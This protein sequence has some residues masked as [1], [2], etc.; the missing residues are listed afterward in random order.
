MN[1]FST[2]ILSLLLTLP[3]AAG[4]SAAM[5]F[6]R[7]EMELVVV[8]GSCAEKEK[9]G[10]RLAL[11]LT[12][13]QGS[14]ANGQPFTGYFNGPDMQTGR[15]SGHDLGQLQVEYPDKPDRPQGDTLW[16]SATPDGL[17]GELREKPQPDSTNCYFEKAVLRLR[18][19]AGDGKAQSEYARQK[20]LF[21]A[22]VYF[23]SGQ[24]LLQSDKPEEALLDLTKSLKLRTMA[25]PNDPDRAIP[26]VSIAIA[27]IMAGREA[28][29]RA[30]MH[31]LYGDK[32]E[33]GDAILKERLALAESLCSAEQYLENDA[34]R[35]AFL[36]LLDMVAREFG[37]LKGAAHPLAACYNEIAREQ[38]DQGDP[39]SAIELFQKA[40]KLDPGNSDSIAGVSMSF[41]DA[42]VPA[43]GRRYLHEHA[44]NF[45]ENAGREP[46]DTLL[47]YLYAAE[48]QEEESGGHFSRAEELC[49]EALKSRPG[50]RTVIIALSRILGKE[51][52]STE[53]RKLLEVGKKACIDQNCRQ[54]YADEVA[55][56]D[57]I[58]QMVQRLEKNSGNAVR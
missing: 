1:R 23:M 29:A 55:R 17:D 54:E 4:A 5:T 21:S 20:N 30:V 49:R 39:E 42:E 51:G 56:Q 13:E 44:A 36:R 7:G 18:Q 33:T 10:S 58:E 14:Q 15:F 11:D 2:V 16:L 40:L 26:A 46:Y 25:N 19:V 57:M 34:G 24:L 32:S 22:E 52:K 53:A 8:S 35:K 3:L 45:I 50:E 31:G 28:E 38:K 27:Q 9:P 48:A 43:E 41:V 6:Y 12:L 47:S 37:G